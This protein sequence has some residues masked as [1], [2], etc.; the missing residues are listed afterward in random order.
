[1]LIQFCWTHLIRDIRFLAE[2]MDKS[3]SLWGRELLDWVRK[4]FETWH[5]AER[6]TEA[7]D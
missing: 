5:R 7:W 1:V 6:M 4:R 2:H 3:L